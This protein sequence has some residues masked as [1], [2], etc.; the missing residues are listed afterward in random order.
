MLGRVI[1]DDD[2][3]YFDR[4]G[5]LTCERTASNCFIAMLVV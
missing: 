1:G 3:Y 5:D 2:V 4:E